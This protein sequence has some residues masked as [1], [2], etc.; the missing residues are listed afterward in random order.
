M[1]C[2]ILKQG[3]TTPDGRLRG[4]ALPRDTSES[5]VRRARVDFDPFGFMISSA[6]SDTV[7]ALR[8]FNSR[9]ARTFLGTRLLTSRH[10]TPPLT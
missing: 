2:G 9:I 7:C 5:S 6:R 4:E 3:R 8:A 1:A 10:T